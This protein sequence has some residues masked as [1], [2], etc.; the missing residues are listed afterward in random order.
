MKPSRFLLASLCALVLAAPTTLAGST[1]TQP[2]PVGVGGYCD[3][4]VHTMCGHETAL[5][6][7]YL[8]LGGDDGACIIYDGSMTGTL[9][10]STPP[11]LVGVGGECDATVHTQCS[12]V[13]ALGVCHLYVGGPD[14]A[15]IVYGGDERVVDSGGECSATIHT[16]CWHWSA[17]GTCGV[18]VGGSDGRCIVY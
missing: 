4:T 18:Y 10:A 14:G 3:H 1:T 2:D 9:A 16:S 6:T 8:F 17:P 11:P 15:C 5:G 12:H 13:T 7:C